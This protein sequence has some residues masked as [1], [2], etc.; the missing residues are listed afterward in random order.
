MDK[1]QIAHDITIS[2]LKNCDNPKEA[3]EKYYE[4]LP[5]VKEEIDKRPPATPPTIYAH[6]H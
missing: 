2:L 6:K 3:V 1:K 4:L 5:I